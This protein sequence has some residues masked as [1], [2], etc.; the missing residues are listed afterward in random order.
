M[1]R[2]SLMR[3]EPV[4]ATTA[5]NARD[6][7]ARARA[8]RWGVP[9]VKLFLA[10]SDI[11][12]AALSFGLAFYL[13]HY[14]SVFSYNSQG[15]FIWTSEF[16]PYAVLLPLIIPIRLLLL[17]YYDLYRMRGEFSFVDDLA[18][19]FKATA[20]ASL[21][22]VA[23]AFM[24]R[25]GI[26]YRTF[27][28]SRAIFLFDF[29][30]ALASIAALRMLLRATQ[31][32]VRRRG[33]NL[34]PTLIV[35]RGTEA[36]QCVRE[37]RARPELGYRIIG[38]IENS[39]PASDTPRY[40]E[41]VPV[42]GDL[43]NLPQAIRD[44]GANEVI[45]SDPTVPGEALFNVMMQTGRRRGVEFRIAP[46][47][48]NCLPSK[49][50]I[51]QVGSLPMVTLFRSP[52]S[53]G[54]RLVKRASDLIVATLALLILAPLWLLVALLIKL[55]SRGPIFYKQERVGMDGRV[56]LFFKFR[57]MHP[58]VDDKEHREFQKKYIKGQAESNQGDGD[59]PAYKLRADRRVTRLGRLLR[60]TSLDE[61]P[62][63]FNVL[64]GDMSIVGPRP[65]IPYE[66][67]SYEL[68]HRK[69]LD[70]KPGI[71]G[72]WQVSGRNR[73][74]FDEMVRMD[75]YY[76]ENWSLLLDLKIMLQTLPVMLRAEDAY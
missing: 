58:G 67:E 50:E 24:Y 49:T 44:S 17:R 23:G 47:L 7:R 33:V 48:L 65:P 46:T 20:I 54:A 53:S 2:G 30:F 43:N 25:G 19:V 55:D 5:L 73:L 66:V 38:V 61:L 16:A 6:V 29:L 22:I 11:V 41:D 35:G 57:T 9:V 36:S 42:I 62:Q 31:I 60:K 76:I 68:W 72:L 26:A 45:I 3:A 40:F 10:L 63:L 74:S 39:Q 12:L 34:I 69:R 18:R 64:R 75:L 51:D 27:S 71:T 15:N 1:N 32:A 59:R 56:F 13:R 70:M 37:M 8:P 28:Y 14:N 52:L 21:L 4:I